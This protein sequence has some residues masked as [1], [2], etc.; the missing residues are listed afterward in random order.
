MRL[1]CNKPVTLQQDFYAALSE[2]L[3]EYERKKEL[4]Q[5]KGGHLL[6]EDK[7]ILLIRWSGIIKNVLYRHLELGCDR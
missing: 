6:G 1:F 3:G 4:A 2:F 5:K 7:A